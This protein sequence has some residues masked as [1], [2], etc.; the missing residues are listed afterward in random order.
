MTLS[1]PQKTFGVSPRWRRWG[2]VVLLMV[3]VGIGTLGW[4]AYTRW[5]AA[6]QLHEVGF[7]FER[8]SDGYPAEWNDARDELGQMDIAKAVQLRNL[9]ALAPALRRVNPE[10][11]DLGNLPA[12]QNL[13]GLKGLTALRELVLYGCDALENVDALKSLTRLEKLCINN[14]RVLRN[15]DVQGL[16]ELRQIVLFDCTALHDVN[17]EGLT[18]LRRLDIYG[19][20]NLQIVSAPSGLPKLEELDTRYCRKL[21]RLPTYPFTVIHPG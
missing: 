11:L 8:I 5:C 1:L 12:L 7:M 3:L 19:C 6:R 10:I 9:D 13:D 21:K 18:K 17:L 2:L 16:A 20:S 15:V 14:C 4:H